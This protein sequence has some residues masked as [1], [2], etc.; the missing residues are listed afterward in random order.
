MAEL[1]QIEEWVAPLLEKLEPAQRKQLART[2]GTEL[3]KSQRQ[4]IAQQK[5]PDGS[6]YTPGQKRR[7]PLN[8]PKR[9]YYERTGRVAELKSYADFGDRYTGYD[10][11]AGGIRTFLKEHIGQYYTPEKSG[12]GSIRQKKGRIKRKMFTKMSSA[13][14][15]KQKHNASA[16]SVGFFG[17]VARI[18]RVHQYGLR[19]RVAKNGPEV[20]YEKRELLGLTEQD[21]TMIEQLLIEH[22][23]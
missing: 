12:G 1:D 11:E 5:N 13:K 16:V 3:R 21:K 2:I 15:L 22:L 23:I 20:Q 19:D 7:A 14:Y 18:A 6:K 8:K 9:F 10:L 4:R 17:S